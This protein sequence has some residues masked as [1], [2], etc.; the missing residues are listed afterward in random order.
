V[1][2]LDAL[3]ADIVIVANGMGAAALLDLPLKGVRGQIT[4]VLGNGV[5]R[6]L[7]VNLHYGGYFSAARAGG[8]HTIGATFQRWLDH[9]DILDEDDVYNVE[10][11]AGFLPA[12]A[13]GLEVIGRRASIRTTA[14]DHFSV[15]GR[16]RDNIYVS[17]AH[18]SHGVVT[19]IGGAQLLADMIMKRDVG[20]SGESVAALCPLRFGDAK[21]RG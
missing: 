3:E 20:L 16:V 14:P 17:T 2:D 13:E 19:S 21:K 1:E 12:L 8:A 10:K 9:T 18:G 5:S 6:D 15:I 4:E 7:K 11:F